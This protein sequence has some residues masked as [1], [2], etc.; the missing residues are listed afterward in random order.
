M[1]KIF[2]T[3]F[4]CVFLCGICFAA[5]YPRITRIEQILYGQVY[6]NEEIYS[7]LDRI[8]TDV[9]GKSQDLSLNKRVNNLYS[10]ITGQN[11]NKEDSKLAIIKV[12]EERI[13]AQTYENAP[14]EERLARLENKMFNNSYS[15][16]DFESR[17]ERIATVAKAQQA[18][19]IYE[20]N[21]LMRTYQ[22]ASTGITM[23]SIALLI[24]KIL[25]F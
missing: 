11:I 9:Y 24:L 23:V 13:L 4:F 5:N 10:T 7:R 14:I 2:L 21:K 17:I 8:E 18:N 22:K 16:E 20:D 12:L 6:E 1:K 25:I 19:E 3:I 15:D